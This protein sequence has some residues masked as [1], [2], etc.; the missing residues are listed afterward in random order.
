MSIAAANLWT[1]NVYKPYLKPA[2]SDA[3]EAA[4][5]KLASLVV[6]VGA[7]AFIIWVP[8]AYAIDLQ[9]LGGIWILQTFPAIVV[10]LYRRFFHDAALF[11]GW[12][13][14][15]LAGTLLSFLQGV[16][17]TFAFTIG[18]VTIAPYIGLVALA[19]NLLVAWALTLVFDRMGVARQADSTMESDY[20]VA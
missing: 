15:M 5:A 16:K 14:G 4:T 13:A 3:D 10:G 6:K 1:R 18:S 19:L 12:A 7:L 17:P 2:A 9:L 20:A 8:T 11:W